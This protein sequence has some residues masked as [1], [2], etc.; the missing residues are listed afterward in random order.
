MAGW[1]EFFDAFC[2]GAEHRVC[3]RRLRPFCAYYRHWLELCHSPLVNEGHVTIVDL[4]IASRICTSRF[5]EAHRALRRPRLGRWLWTLRALRYDAG[6]E[7]QRFAAYVKDHTSGPKRR[8]DLISD[9][10]GNAG[11]R[12]RL[13]K[14]PPTLQMVCEL[15]WQTK[16]EEE[17]A[18]MMPMGR[19]LWLL[20]GFRRI[21]GMDDKGM[22]TEHDREFIEGLAAQ[23]CGKKGKKDKR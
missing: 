11:E 6:R 9:L 13:Q 12:N 19:M 20:A 21:E 10:T 2:E 14:L 18:W 7:G 16:W 17:R 4:E 3:G 23:K 22:L 15:I 5:G 1:P 8:E